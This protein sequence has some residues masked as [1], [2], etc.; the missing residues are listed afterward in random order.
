MVQLATTYVQPRGLFKAETLLAD[1]VDMIQDRRLRAAA[2]RHAR[3]INPK[4]H[5]IWA[6]VRRRQQLELETITI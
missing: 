2:W 3:R 4:A 5:V 6:A 1:V